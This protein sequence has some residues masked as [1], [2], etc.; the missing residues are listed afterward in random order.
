MPF[1]SLTLDLDITYILVLAL[2]L[3]PLV[4]LNGLVFKPF[5]KLFEQRHEQLQ[6][7]LERANEK[8]ENAEEKA[9][10]FEA[11]I[12]VAT[13]R[14]LDARNAIRAEAQKQMNARIE[15]ERQ[16]LAKKLEGALGEID[17]AKRA[18]RDQVTAESA[19]L[20]EVTAAKLLG[21]R[22]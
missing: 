15:E 16:R 12:Q 20:A 10:A 18:A 17:T 14:G 2:L 9:K 4:I 1:A 21:R 8:L 13:A 22:I 6:G 11:K 5:L 3:V 19:V 7:A